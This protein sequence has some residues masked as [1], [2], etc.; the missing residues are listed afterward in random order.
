MENSQPND[1]GCGCDS[2]DGTAALEITKH[3]A[4][5]G[6]TSGVEKEQAK[7]NEQLV[8]VESFSPRKYCWLLVHA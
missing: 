2:G 6:G 5:S 3:T 4:K 1:N 8:A 7:W